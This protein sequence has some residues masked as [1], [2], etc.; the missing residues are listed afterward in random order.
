MSKAK[1]QS[2]PIFDQNYSRN[3]GRIHHKGTETQSPERLFSGSQPEYLQELAEAAD[4]ADGAD[5]CRTFSFS[6]FQLG[7]HQSV[8][9]QLV[10]ALASCQCLERGALM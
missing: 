3:T 7:P 8:R 5:K 9:H 1:E 10:Q 2:S 6:I 4:Y